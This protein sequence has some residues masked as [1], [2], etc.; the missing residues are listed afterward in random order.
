MAAT[1]GDYT[2][3]IIVFD[4]CS[5]TQ[6]DYHER[7]IRIDPVCGTAT[8]TPTNTP[9]LT[10]TPTST[11]APFRFYLPVILKGCIDLGAK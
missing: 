5:E 8:P 7:I 4:T 3:Q 1:P 6:N 11:P 9:T 2:L 10:P